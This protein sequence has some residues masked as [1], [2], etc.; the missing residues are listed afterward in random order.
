MKLSPDVAL[1]VAKQELARH[2]R[3][4]GDLETAD[5]IEYGSSVP[6]SERLFDGQESFVKSL[7]WST[8][9]EIE[10]SCGESWSPSTAHLMPGT[11]NHEAATEAD[12]R[13]ALTFTVSDK[14]RLAWLVS[15]SSQRQVSYRACEYLLSKLLEQRSEIPTELVEFG[16]KALRREVSQP[17]EQGGG[18]GKKDIADACIVLAIHN[19]SSFYDIPPTGNDEPATGQP[20]NAAHY[21][22]LAANISTSKARGLWKESRTANGRKRY[23]KVRRT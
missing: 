15:E 4:Y 16:A 12:K 9:I 18:A 19:I 13:G 2:F 20:H 5:S 11:A 23:L 6:A 22:A 7:A 3:R 8:G 1:I 14:G 10:D 17:A 21:V